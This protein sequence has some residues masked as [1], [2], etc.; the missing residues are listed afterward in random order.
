MKGEDDMDKI[1]VKGLKVF[2]HHGVYPEESAQGQ[3]F[4]VS[5]TLDV[6]TRA[7]GL[8]DDLDASVD[9]G[10]LCLFIVGAKI[11]KISQISK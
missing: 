7:A 3:N 8:S 4:Y 1:Q 5:A 10:D 2:A 9:Y 6:D 11:V